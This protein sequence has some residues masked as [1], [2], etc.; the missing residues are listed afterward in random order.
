MLRKLLP[1]VLGLIGTAGGVAA[2]KL[3]HP[4]AEDVVQ[5]T[6]AP[7]EQTDHADQITGDAGT[8]QDANA[9]DL[10][11]V[12]LNNQFIV[13]VVEDGKVDAL[14][15]M[16]LS[17]EITQGHREDVFRV[18]PKLRDVFLSVLYDHANTGGFRGEFTRNDR[19]T[20]LRN[21][22]AEVARSTLGHVV[23]D[24]LIQDLNR[25]DI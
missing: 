14:V 7:Q 8:D 6:C 4:P 15:V 24:V 13:P 9:V 19:I 18:A 20:V 5:N 22:L 3:L 17:L 10:D 11:Y 23:S 12:R 2:A 1:L 21:A 16:S 25:Q